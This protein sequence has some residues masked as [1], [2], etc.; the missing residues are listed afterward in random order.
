MSV[1]CGSWR[2]RRA[3]LAAQSVKQS[4]A[5][6]SAAHS[7]ARGQVSLN[8]LRGRTRLLG[9][10]ATDGAGVVPQVLRRIRV[11]EDR[12]RIFQ[13]DAAALEETQ[14]NHGVALAVSFVVEQDVA[15]G[16]VVKL[17]GQGL[18][19]DAVW[20]VLTLPR[21]Q[22]DVRRGRVDPIRHHSPSHTGHAGS[23]VNLSHFKQ[24]VHV[25]LWISRTLWS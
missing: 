18:Q 20:S 2:T 6:R 13:S 1:P 24:S 19:T 11:S 10:A 23:G 7:L 17:A 8:Q 15:K 3:V 12:Q 21:T 14:R 16:R 25:T 4:L 22:P 9:P 5:H